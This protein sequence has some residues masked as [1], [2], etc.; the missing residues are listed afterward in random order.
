[1]SG[2]KDNSLKSFTVAFIPDCSL[3]HPSIQDFSNLTFEDLYLMSN[4]EEVKA[5]NCLL[6]SC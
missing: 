1:M 5:L 4:E 3:A 2:S 6:I